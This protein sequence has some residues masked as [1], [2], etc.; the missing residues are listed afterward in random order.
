MHDPWEIWLRHVARRDALPTREAS[1]STSAPMLGAA[2]H[3]RQVVAVE[4]DASD[5]RR[6][7]GTRRHASLVTVRRRS[8]VRP[9][10]QGG[11]RWS[12]EIASLPLFVMSA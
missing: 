1:S 6:R 4:R 8:D 12:R 9:R 2:P 11:A 5:D 10:D 3:S 7:E